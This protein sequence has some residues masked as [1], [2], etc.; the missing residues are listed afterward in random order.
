MGLPPDALVVGTLGR[1]T[2]DKGGQ[3]DLLRA[4]AGVAALA[5]EG[6]PVRLLIVGDGPLRPELET[7]SA[8]L[9]LGERAVF[10]GLK[11]GPEVARLLG[12]MDVFVLP[13]HREALPIAL[14][15]AMSVGLPVVATNVG[16]IPEIIEDGANGLLVAP[17]EP[18]ALQRS[19][20]RLFAGSELRSDL[21]RAARAHVQANFT[22][23][24][25]TKRVE[26]LYEELYAARGKRAR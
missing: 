7:L 4:V 21:G 24:Q 20:E 5:P 19:L 2:P 17:A 11:A 9:G 26:Q 25:T 8:D 3:D 22:L 15:E 16:G 12:C 10:A 13:S 23:E 14:L 6:R 18:S 1:L